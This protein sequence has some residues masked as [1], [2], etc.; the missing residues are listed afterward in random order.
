MSDTEL[1]DA[2]RSGEIDRIIGA[3]DEESAR[4]VDS[5]PLGPSLSRLLSEPIAGFFGA[6]RFGLIGA[7]D[8]AV[9]RF[10]LEAKRFERERAVAPKIEWFR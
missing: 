8:M 10:V 1:T 4:R 2:I 3:M 6:V 9:Y 7:I 5:D